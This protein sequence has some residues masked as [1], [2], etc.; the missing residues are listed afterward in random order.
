LDPG[1]TRELTGPKRTGMR[2]LV[3]LFEPA[4]GRAGFGDL[5]ARLAI[6]QAGLADVPPA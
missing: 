3:A 2:A 4:A 1:L 6:I 5:A